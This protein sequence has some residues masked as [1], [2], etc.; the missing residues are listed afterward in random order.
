MKTFSIR[1]TIQIHSIYNPLESPVALLALDGYLDTFNSKPFQDYILQMIK[2][3]VTFI[4][5]DCQKLSYVSSTGIGSFNAITSV[6]Q[7]KKGDL[8]LLNLNAK[9]MNVLEMLGF[10]KYFR[11]FHQM[12]SC[13][14]YLKSKSSDVQI[15]EEVLSPYFSREITGELDIFPTVMDCPSCQNAF[16]VMK[17]GLFKCPHCRMKVRVNHKAEAKLESNEPY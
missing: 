3:S 4:I 8:I 12:D 14:S 5:L 2:N 7:N 10:A 1:D 15:P 9:V 6:L 17:P 11:I 13:L 16:K